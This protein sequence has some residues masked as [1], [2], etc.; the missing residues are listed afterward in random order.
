[1]RCEITGGQP[2]GPT[3]D[4]SS[5]APALVDQCQGDTTAVPPRACCAAVLAT[6][7]NRDTG[8]LCTVSSE[9]D[10]V[11]SALDVPLMWELY[12]R[13]GGKQRV[14]DT[15]SES[16][17]PAPAAAP[18]PPPPPSTPPPPRRPP[19]TP[20]AAK[21][22]AGLSHAGWIAV[23]WTCSVLGGTAVVIA[24]VYGVKLAIRR[25]RAR[26]GTRGTRAASHPDGTRITVPAGGMAPVDAVV[27]QSAATVRVTVAPGARGG[28]SSDAGLV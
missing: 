23:I 3:C 5:L 15:T 13:C 28:G 26:R 22:Q 25:N 2:A 11:E 21:P 6:V 16:C 4:V 7:D 1:M 9:G 27:S 24:T 10:F 8:C 12:R 17:S 19:P 20:P 14:P 18:P